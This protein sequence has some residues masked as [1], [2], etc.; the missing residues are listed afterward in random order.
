ML[1]WSLHTRGPRDPQGPRACAQSILNMH[2]KCIF[3]KCALHG[4]VHTYCAKRLNKSK[5]A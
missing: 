3:N 4:N 1:Q 2:L 5:A